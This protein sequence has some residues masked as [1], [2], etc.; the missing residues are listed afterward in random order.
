MWRELCKKTLRSFAT[1]HNGQCCFR[2]KQH[3]LVSKI[4]HEMLV[5]RG[6]SDPLTSLDGMAS[7]RAKVKNASFLNI[8]FAG[9]VAFDDAP[10]MFLQAVGTFL[11]V[12][13]TSNSRE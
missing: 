10:D 11:G 1:I 12:A 2:R 9:H 6:D 7:L 5:V 13:F 8:P 4:A 3:A